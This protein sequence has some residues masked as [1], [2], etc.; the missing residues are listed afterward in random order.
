LRDSIELWLALNGQIE[1]LA[2]GEPI[3]ELLLPPLNL[4]AHQ[5]G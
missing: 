1:F 2:I 4:N 5:T 3:W